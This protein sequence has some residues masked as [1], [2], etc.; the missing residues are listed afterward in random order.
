MSNQCSLKVKMTCPR[1]GA[2]SPWVSCISAHL[3][4]KML[5]CFIKDSFQGCLYSKQLVMRFLYSLFSLEWIKLKTLRIPWFGY[6]ME[7]LHSDFSTRDILKLG[8]W[9]VSCFS[10]IILTVINDF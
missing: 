1:L 6:D 5:V 9:S 4:S 3:P 2:N 7:K 8:I 10:D